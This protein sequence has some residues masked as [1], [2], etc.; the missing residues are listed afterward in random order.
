MSLAELYS[1]HKCDTGYENNYAAGKDIAT[2]NHRTTDCVIA[3]RLKDN[4]GMI[5]TF[6]DRNENI[7]RGEIIPE[8]NIYYVD[9]LA[10]ELNTEKL[11]IMLCKYANDINTSNQAEIFTI[12]AKVHERLTE[13]ISTNPLTQEL[14]DNMCY[15]SPAVKSARN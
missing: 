3:L 7:I 14:L 2:Y 10:Q 6:S 4:V 15:I 13:I 8:S 5:I 12:L 11:G 9:P 1:V